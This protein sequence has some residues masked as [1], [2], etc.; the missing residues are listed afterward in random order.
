MGLKR[1]TAVK[2]LGRKNFFRHDNLIALIFITVVLGFALGLNYFIF[3]YFCLGLLIVR[4]FEI[5]FEMKQDLFD[6]PFLH[7]LVLIGIPIQLLWTKYH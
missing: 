7:Y 3:T 5:I 2:G 6:R 1:L 4:V